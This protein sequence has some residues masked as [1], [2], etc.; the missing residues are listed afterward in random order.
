MRRII[1]AFEDDSNESESGNFSNDA[2]KKAT[3]ERAKTDEDMFAS[4]ASNE[5]ANREV[6]PETIPPFQFRER[7]DSDSRSQACK[8]PLPKSTN[9]L[10]MISPVAQLTALN[11]S[12]E[13]AKKS[14]SKTNNFDLG[15]ISSQNTPTEGR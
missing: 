10:S 8:T 1:T 6:E 12:L 14:A 2:S 4:Q 11:T 3:L 15:R 13:S 5:C 7:C 9:I